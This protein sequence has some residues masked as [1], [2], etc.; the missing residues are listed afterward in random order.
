M[1]VTSERPQYP[2]MLTKFT[3][4]RKLT[5]TGLD[6]HGS[7][8][9]TEHHKETL[10]NSRLSE[11]FGIPVMA[12]LRERFHGRGTH[13]AEAGHGKKGTEEAVRA[14]VNIRVMKELL[15]YQKYFHRIS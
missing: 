10:H 1:V 7:E 15:K 3:Q 11:E 12:T 8:S 9:R 6:Q 13:D 4:D 2:K 14:G 5:P